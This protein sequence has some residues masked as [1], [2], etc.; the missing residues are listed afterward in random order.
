MPMRLNYR[1]LKLLMPKAPGSPLTAV[2]S[3][4]RQDQRSPA[5]PVNGEDA[6][7]MEVYKNSDANV[8]STVDNVNKKLETLRQDNPEYTLL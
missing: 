1:R 2:A 5:M 4:K 8:V 3:I 6:I 7:V